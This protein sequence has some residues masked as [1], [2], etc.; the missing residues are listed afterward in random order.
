VTR[1]TDPGTAPAETSPALVVVSHGASARL[2][3]EDGREVLARAPGRRLQYVCGDRVLAV[4]DP[5]HDQW[6]LQSVGPRTS[7][8]QRTNAR[9]QAEPVAANLTRLVVVVAPRPEPDLFL[10]DRYLAAA[11]SAG[12][13]CLLVMGKADLGFEAEA[14][15]ALAGL[16]SVGCEALPCSAHTGMGLDALRERLARERV[17]LVGQS[18]VGKSSLLR[19]L[20]PGADAAIGEL[21]RD[22]SGRHTTSVSRLYDLPGG[23]ALIDSPGVRDF[24]P[25]P[26]DLEPA[27]LGFHEVERLAPGCRF[28]NCRHMEEPGCAVRAGVADGGMAARRYESYRRLRRLHNDLLERAGP[29]RR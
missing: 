1:R 29:R 3:L 27:S 14:S 15:A 4:R 19:A 16:A 2:R 11:A 6:L 12:I 8:L 7:L 24:A 5:Q 25:A 9:G 20:V 22:D 10:V 13:G 26:E 18:G 28:A 17:M 23:G 21:M